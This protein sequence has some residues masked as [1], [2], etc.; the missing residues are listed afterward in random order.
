MCGSNPLLFRKKLEIKSSLPIV[1]HCAQEVWFMGK[2]FLSLCYPFWGGCCLCSLMCRNHS[3]SFGFLSKGIVAC[4]AVYLVYLWE[5]GK[6]GAPY[7]AVLWYQSCQCLFLDAT[8]LVSENAGPILLTWPM[9]LNSKM[10]IGTGSFVSTDQG[11]NLLI[12]VIFPSHVCM[13]QEGG[14]PVWFAAVLFPV[15]G[16]GL[17]VL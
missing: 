4:A 13:A 11:Y 6:S 10:G 3:S 12:C 7:V 9:T 5:E 15:L 1:C 2:V 17:D 8:P 16:Q 14:D